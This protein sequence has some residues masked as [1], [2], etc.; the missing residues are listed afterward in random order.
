MKSLIWNIF[1]LKKY[2][3]VSNENPHIVNI[4]FCCLYNLDH[5]KIWSEITPICI[6]FGALAPLLP[7]FSN[8]NE[9][10][11]GD[12][13]SLPNLPEQKLRP[14]VLRDS[15]LVTTTWSPHPRPPTYYKLYF[16]KV[17]RTSYFFTTGR[18]NQEKTITENWLLKSN[19]KY[20]SNVYYHWNFP[21]FT[22]AI[23]IGAAW[24]ILKSQP[25]EKTQKYHSELMKKL[26]KNSR[27]LADLKTKR[28][29][30]WLKIFSRSTCSAK[31]TPR[32][33]K[34]KKDSLRESNVRSQRS[35]PKKATEKAGNASS[36]TFQHL[37]CK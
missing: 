10:L 6:N 34:V 35:F 9:M 22:T 23:Q 20:G 29:L 2:N 30:R 33:S 13:F 1:L 3:F 15:N 36:S 14:C 17:T 32:F 8:K 11:G 4:F 31:K 5:C 19:P 28:H 27:L 16:Q 7:Y 12:Q 24:T 37:P 21:A 18:R 25:L 26:S